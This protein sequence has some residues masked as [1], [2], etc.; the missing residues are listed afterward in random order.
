MSSPI[1]IHRYRL[2]GR[3]DFN[4][5]TARRE[6]PGALIRCDGGVGC[7]HPWPEFGDDPLEA[8]LDALRAGQ[9]GRLARIALRCAAADAEARAA[10]RSLFAGLT[11]PDSHWLWCAE[12]EFDPQIAEASEYA[13]TKVKALPDRAEFA[14][15]LDRIA[16][17]S[18][19][20]LRLDFNATLTAE[21]FRAF[22]GDLGDLARSRIE[23]IEDP[24]PYDPAIWGELQEETGLPF[25]L[26]QWFGEANGGFRMAVVKPSRDAETDWNAGGLQD[27][28]LIMTSA[29][30]HPIG[31][32]FAAWESAKAARRELG[33]I[34]ECGLLTHRWFEPDPFIEA[35]RSQGPKLLPAEGTGLGYDALLEDLPWEPL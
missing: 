18:E 13:A 31:Q 3:R 34:R 12:R 4:P 5:K 29:M 2:T 33:R 30:D 21:E 11:I 28:P 19:L 7:L 24:V 32:M 1:Q 10:G 8:Q 20:R 9:P 15:L 22:A 26:D 23:C 6:F 27:I 35:T 16:Q 17:G 14:A 25:A